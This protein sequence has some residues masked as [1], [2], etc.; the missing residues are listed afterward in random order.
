M[1]FELK[2]DELRDLVEHG[3]Q[4]I[5]VRSN[6]EYSRG[7]LKDAVNIPL[8]SIPHNTEAIDK[9]K[10]VMLYCVSGMRANAV[11]QFLE[12]LGFNYVYNLGGISQLAHC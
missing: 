11:K 6:H 8:E 10:P 2:C 3:G 7:A 12:S 9:S 4:L 5:D 1:T